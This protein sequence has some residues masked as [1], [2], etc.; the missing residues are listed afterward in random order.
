MKVNGNILLDKKGSFSNI[1]QHN[2]EYAV[3]DFASM[4]KEADKSKDT[5]YYDSDEWF[6]F[7]AKSYSPKDPYWHGVGDIAYTL[8][9]GV[10]NPVFKPIQVENV[11]EFESKPM[12]KIHGG[13]LCDGCSQENYVY[14]KQSINKWHDQWF[15]DNPEKIDWNKSAND[16]L[17]C[18][19]RTIDI[20]REELQ[21]LKDC[22]DSINKLEYSDKKYIMSVELDGLEA[23][24][25]VSKF[26]SLIMDHKDESGEKVSYAKEIGSKICELNYYHHEKEL[27]EL[28]NDNQQIVK[29]YSIKKDDKYQFLSI[30]KRHG[31][32][33]WCNEKGDHICEVMFD[34][35]SVKNS[36]DANHSI[37]QIDNW[38]RIYKK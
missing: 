25:I 38:K 9:L 11:E 10:S 15:M 4:V 28:N 12:P 37:S 19:D 14:D 16:V 27:E 17:P 6:Q 35:E 32:F 3:Y 33:E 34:G 8:L 22:P 29:I 18:Y 36:Q 20:L 26:Y 13:F 7:H 24:Q 1:N 30:D 5:L 21:K 31:R 2:A 23:K